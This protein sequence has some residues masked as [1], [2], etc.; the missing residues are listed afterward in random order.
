MT[1]Q[2]PRSAPDLRRLSCVEISYRTKRGSS[3]TP[4][5]EKYTHVQNIYS[6]TA[7]RRNSQQ[8]PLENLHVPYMKDPKYKK[9]KRSHSMQ[10]SSRLI[11]CDSTS[12]LLFRQRFASY[13]SDVRA[14]EDSRFS[15]FVGGDGCYQRLRNFSVTSKG[16]LNQGDSFRSSPCNLSSLVSQVHS[17]FENKDNVLNSPTILHHSFIG[18]RDIPV[19]T[20][21]VIVTGSSEVGKSFL[22]QQFTTSEY[23]CTYDNMTE[24]GD[25]TAVTVVLN[26]EES[27]LVFTEQTLVDDEPPCTSYNANCHVV[28]YSTADRS[29]FQSA[30]CFL[31]KLSDSEGVTQ[32]I[33]LVGN[34]T[35]LVR[36]RSVT[37]NEGRKLAREYGCK[38]IETSACINYH[39]DELLVGVVT[40]IRLK[41]QREQQ[42]QKKKTSIRPEKSEYKKNDDSLRSNNRTLSLR[43][44]LERLFRKSRSCDN[45]NVL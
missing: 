42:N 38:F 7:V 23:M 31:D 44:L 15:S 12:T 5:I 2:V 9:T 20:Y 45:F 39:L 30:K 25:N 26:E 29:S 40:Q 34:K 16:V 6:L 13:P 10:S 1:L 27:T 4:A 21:T 18:E 37:T 24:E 41:I 32:P 28:V 43:K 3:L 17:G 11:N 36:L 19:T 8:R 14:L 22:T 35:D 33:V